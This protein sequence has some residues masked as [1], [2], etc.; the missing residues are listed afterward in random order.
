MKSSRGSRVSLF[1]ASVLLV[2]VLGAG[3]AIVVLTST[4]RHNTVELADG[5]APAALL[6]LNI[7]RDAYQAELF[8]ERVVHL[9][10]T[11]LESI[12]ARIGY[13]ENSAQLV[14]ERWTGFREIGRELRDRLPAEAQHADMFERDRDIWLATAATV[15]NLSPGPDREILT[16]TAREQFATM[17][18]HLDILEE[19]VWEPQI[20]ILGSSTTRGIS[21]VMVTIVVTMIVVAV[22][23]VALTITNIVAFRRQAQDYSRREEDLL[24]NTR[25]QSFET[26]LRRALEMAQTEAAALGIVARATD[27]SLE[28]VEMSELLLSDSSRTQLRSAQRRAVGAARGCGVTTPDECRAV[29]TG[30]MQVFS[31]SAALD[32]CP[33][34]ADRDPVRRTA[35]CV[36]VSINGRASGTLHATRSA[37]DPFDERD[38]TTLTAIAN[39]TGIQL[40]VL[41]NQEIATHQASTDP[42]T[43][44]ANRR[45]L[46]TA[47]HRMRESAE[48]MA[49]LMIDL[50]HFKELNDAHGHETGDRALRIFADA[51]RDVAYDDRTVAARWG[52]EE[53]VIVVADGTVDDG[54]LLAER[55]REALA[56][57]L[58]DDTTP[59]FTVSIGVVSTDWSRPFD[60]ALE[61]ADQALYE[62]KESGRDRVVVG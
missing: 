28:R 11:G 58:L 36:P 59:S 44:L 10:A 35:I 55:L 60:E 54:I 48:C 61:S 2:V 25:R 4:A 17:R 12:S 26:L 50:D 34:L 16:E 5:V 51:A 19:E 62:A 57:K 9:E 56:V 46:D 37:A 3:T 38:Q 24:E 14:G 1:L 52:G 43:G 18:E 27:Q 53:F 8:L 42:L 30:T 31:D 41:R 7:D 23:T 13:A 20:G 6:L 45:S 32:A 21:L 29:V 47:V 49:I 33:Y 15:L 39:H 22:V 40:S